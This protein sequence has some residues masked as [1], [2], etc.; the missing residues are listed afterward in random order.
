[1]YS[2]LFPR[3]N[4]KPCDGGPLR[5][6]LPVGQTPTAARPS[7]PGSG[8]AFRTSGYIN[9]IHVIRGLP[10]VL[11][12]GRWGKAPKHGPGD[13]RVK[14]LGAIALDVA[15]SPPPHDLLHLRKCHIQ[16]WKG[17]RHWETRRVE[18]VDPDGGKGAGGPDNVAPPTGGATMG[19]GGEGGWASRTATISKT[20]NVSNINLLCNKKAYG[21]Q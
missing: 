16:Y 2:G 9:F 15:V 8:G 10:V 13:V 4:P 17:S 7:H 3:G 20:V 6:H 19:G 1:M 18:P 12:N 21:E 11:S 14:P 5:R